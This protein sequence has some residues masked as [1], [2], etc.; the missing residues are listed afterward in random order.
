MN[1]VADEWQKHCDYFIE[2]Y[3]TR[4]EGLNKGLKSIAANYNKK[5][6]ELQKSLDEDLRPYSLKVRKIQDGVRRYCERAFK[7]EESNFSFEILPLPEP[8]VNPDNSDWLFDSSRSF[9]H[10]LN[11]FKSSR[12][13]QVKTKKQR[14]GKGKHKDNNN[15]NK[16][17]ES[18]DEN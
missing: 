2:K 18:Q 7:D 17:S 10:Q 4:I 13:Q 15:S 5:L 6:T 14:K 1:D 3:N 8:D 16:K 11:V 12:P 9:M